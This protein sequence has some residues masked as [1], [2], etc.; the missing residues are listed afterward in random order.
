MAA[1]A[2]VPDASIV[3]KWFLEEED[4][5][6]ARFLLEL[7]LR[8]EVEFRIPELLHY[9]VANALRY[10]KGVPGGQ[11]EVHLEVLLGYEFETAALTPALLTSAVR[12]A[13]ALGATVYDSIYLAL[14]KSLNAVMVTADAEFDRKARSRHVTTLAKAYAELHS[15]GG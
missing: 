8:E 5:S 13:R 1:V 3:V 2:L 4:S 7:C 10:A 14:A 12:E 6:Q 11:A 15:G 9:E